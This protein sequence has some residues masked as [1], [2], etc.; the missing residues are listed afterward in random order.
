VANKTNKLP[1]LIDTIPTWARFNANYITLKNVKMF[2]K[3]FYFQYFK[4]IV[5]GKYII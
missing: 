5:E 4:K 2:Q 3:I 1:S